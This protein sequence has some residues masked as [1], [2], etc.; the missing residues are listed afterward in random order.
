VLEQVAFEVVEDVAREGT[1]KVELRWSP[2]FVCELS[3]LPWADALDGFEAGLARARL[4]YPQVQ[5][6]MLCIASR[7]YGVDSAAETVEFF[8]K[9][10]DRFI[11]IDLAGNEEDFPCRLFERAFKPV[12]DKDLRIT[13][14]AGEATGPDNVWEAIEY[15][16]AQ[17]IGHGINSLKD[18]SL[19]E[20][21]KRDSIC[22]E[23]CP[24]SNWLTRCVP[25]LE[26]HPLPKALR[27]G[28]PVC[29]NTDDPGVFAV[30]LRDEIKICRERMGMSDAEIQA[31]FAHA[32]KASFLR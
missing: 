14:H 26:E 19:V 23:M 9:N 30:T 2:G 32:E 29:I 1:E 24:T 21:L 13:V 25:S 3:K 16:G 15:L 20:R 6:G 5:T 27:A 17:R 11:G 12:R 10:R 31:C 7:D 28:I 18:A 4:S 8:V 22:L